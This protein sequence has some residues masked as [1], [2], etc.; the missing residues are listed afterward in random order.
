[1]KPRKPFSRTSTPLALLRHPKHRGEWAQIQFMAESARR[2]LHV[3]LPYGDSSHYDLVIGSATGLH[4]VQV[5]STSVFRNFCYRAEIHRIY[6]P[7]DID[8]LAIYVIAGDLWYIIPAKDLPP[9]RVFSL[10]PHR[11]G[12]RGKYEKYKDAWHLLGYPTHM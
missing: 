12:S 3:L 4:R 9:K 1:M 11:I 6:T 2:G 10:F 5:K 7:D 8:F